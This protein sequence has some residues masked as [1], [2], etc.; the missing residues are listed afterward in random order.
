MFIVMDCIPHDPPLHLTTDTCQSSAFI[1]STMSLSGLVWEHRYTYLQTSYCK[2]QWSSSNAVILVTLKSYK[3]FSSLPIRIQAIPIISLS[4]VLPSVCVCVCS[5]CIVLINLPIHC[6]TDS[7]TVIVY[8]SCCDIYKN[9]YICRHTFAMQI[10]CKKGI[11]RTPIEFS[12]KY[13]SSKYTHRL[14]GLKITF[15]QQRY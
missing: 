4:C 1:T 12:C 14:K 15:I 5:C 10:R 7:T 3:I 9:Q 6:S 13:Y 11:E 8:K 2:L